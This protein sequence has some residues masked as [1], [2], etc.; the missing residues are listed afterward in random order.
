M[1]DNGSTHVYDIMGH[2][3]Y[4]LTSCKQGTLA[5][6]TAI[7]VPMTKVTI[8]V[9]I[10]HDSHKVDLEFRNKNTEDQTFAVASTRLSWQVG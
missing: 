2:L 4:S 1:T 7:V 3:F 6:E 9:D 10:S 8:W 5:V